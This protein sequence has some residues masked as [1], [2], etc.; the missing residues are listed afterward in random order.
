MVQGDTAKGGQWA[1]VWLWGL[2]LHP[3]APLDTHFPPAGEG[4]TPLQGK[5]ML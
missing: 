3:P 1:P 4:V 5:G 2:P